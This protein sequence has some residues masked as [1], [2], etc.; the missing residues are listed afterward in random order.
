MNVYWI[1]MLQNGAQQ[2]GFS[3]DKMHVVVE[4]KTFEQ[5]H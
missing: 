5:Y 2:N 1:V 3:D 4:K